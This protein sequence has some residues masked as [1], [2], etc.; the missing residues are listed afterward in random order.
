MKHHKKEIYVGFQK[1]SSFWNGLHRKENRKK[2]QAEDIK[3]QTPQ[4]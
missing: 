1:I 4:N 2:L 3:I